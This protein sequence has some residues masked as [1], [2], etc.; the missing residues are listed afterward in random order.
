MSGKPIKTAEG[1]YK[2][3]NGVK[4][5]QH[6]YLVDGEGNIVDHNGNI[7]FD[8]NVLVNQGQLPSL[9]TRLAKTE[10]DDDLDNLLN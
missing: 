2:D 7:M 9:F 1:G 10:S 6:G 3:D 4:V 8:E 5:N